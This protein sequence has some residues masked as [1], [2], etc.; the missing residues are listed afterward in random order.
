[1]SIR[2]GGMDARYTEVSIATA[3]EEVGEDFIAEGHLG[4]VLASDH[5][6]VIEGTPEE[7]LL[8]VSR[9]NVA[10]LRV[11]FRQEET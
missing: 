4:L 2:W 10:L 6:L 9:I 3:G 7:L 8:L 5:A 1:M 11:T